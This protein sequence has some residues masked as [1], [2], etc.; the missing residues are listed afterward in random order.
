MS[1]PEVKVSFTA[2]VMAAGRAIETRRSDALFADPFA[3]QL[4]GPE[5]IQEFMPILAEY[6]RQG[7]PLSVV[8]TRFFDDFLISHSSKLRQIV[9]LGA[10]LD[11]RAFR[12]NWQVGTRVYEI[13]Q[14]DV[15]SYKASVLTEV[16]PNC[17][18]HS[19]GADL[20]ESLWPELLLGQGYQPSEPSIWL[21]EGFLYY[22]SPTAVHNLLT[23]L[24][25]LTS[26]GSWLGMDLI[27]SV[28]LN[29]ADAWTRYWQSSC[30]HPESFL[31]NYGWKA[32]ALQP[33][34]A[35]AAFGRFT[36]RFPDRDVPDAPRMFFVT[37]CKQ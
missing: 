8:R 7:R 35:G 23:S 33:G 6:E 19:I 18:C 16:Q 36:Y 13:D 31:A 14:T 27:N 30:D 1:E 28:T 34:E 11:T 32:S 21:L 10:G 25:T 4:A 26:P 3:E 37:A 15:L 5:T 29:G 24:T 17:E 22:L 2:K 20:Q 9:L 12:L